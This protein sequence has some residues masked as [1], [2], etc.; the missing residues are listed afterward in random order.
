MDQYKHYPHLRAEASEASGNKVTGTNWRP[1]L[2]HHMAHACD[3]GHWKVAGGGAEIHLLDDILLTGCRGPDCGTHCLSGVTTSRTSALTVEFWRLP[4]NRRSSSHI[5]CFS[6]ARIQAGLGLGWKPQELGLPILRPLLPSCLAHLCRQAGCRPGWCLACPPRTAR[7]CWHWS[8]TP[9]AAA[10][11]PLRRW[12][13]TVTGRPGPGRPQWPRKSRW[14][15]KRGSELQS[16]QCPGQKDTE[17]GANLTR[18]TSKD[19]F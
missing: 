12:Q 19:C 2:L 14:R 17:K 13:S 18:G 8:G 1:G 16:G 5:S 15:E 4:V 10:G 9:P 6:G 11:Q 3:T 7:H